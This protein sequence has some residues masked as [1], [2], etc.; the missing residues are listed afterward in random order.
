MFKATG[1]RRR[2]NGPIIGVEK[3]RTIFDAEISR[4]F[5]FKAGSVAPRRLFEPKADPGPPQN[6]DRFCQ[7]HRLNGIRIGRIERIKPAI[8]QKIRSIRTRRIP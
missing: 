7:G 5:R 4:I 1:R 6:R 3:R 8:I 2:R